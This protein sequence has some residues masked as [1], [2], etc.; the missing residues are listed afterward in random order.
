MFDPKGRTSEIASMKALSI[1]ID[2]KGYRLDPS[3]IVEWPT[4]RNGWISIMVDIDSNISNRLI[5]AKRVGFYTQYSYDA[6]VFFG[7]SDM[8]FRDGAVKYQALLKTCP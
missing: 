3:R 7:I 8:D 5:S 6:P 4:A 2:G 1:E